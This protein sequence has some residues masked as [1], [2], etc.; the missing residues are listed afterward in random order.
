MG[1]TLTQLWVNDK[2]GL[3]RD[4]ILGYDDNVSK[5]RLSVACFLSN[6]LICLDQVIHRPRTP[7]FQRHRGTICQ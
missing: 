4:V 3:K 6:A 2:N 1:A 7:V 5:T